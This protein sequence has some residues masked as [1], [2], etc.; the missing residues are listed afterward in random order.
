[1][2]HLMLFPMLNILYFYIST[3]R[4]VCAVPNMAGIIVIIHSEFHK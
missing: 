1:M 4:C 2:V 3:F